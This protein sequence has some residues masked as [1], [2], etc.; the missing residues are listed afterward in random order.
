VSNLLKLI[1]DEDVLR[2][3][4][5]Y[6]GAHTGRVSASTSK[7]SGEEQTDRR[8]NPLNIPKF[9]VFGVD[10]RGMLIPRPGHKFM[11]YDYSQIEARIVQWMAGNAEFLEYVRR[12]GDIYQA[13]AKFVGWYSGTNLKKDNPGMRQLSK[14]A[15]L[16]LGYGMGPDKFIVTADKPMYGNLKISEGQAVQVVGEFRERNN[17][18]VDLWHYHHDAMRLS[19]IMQDPTHVI[20][21]PSGRKMTYY[22]PHELP[23]FRLFKNRET[24]KMENK[25]VTELFAATTMY[26]PPEKYFGGKIV[27]NVVQSTARDIMFHGACSIERAHPNWYFLFNAYDEVIFEVPETDVPLAQAEMPRLLCDVPWAA[28]CPLEVD[29]GKTNGVHDRYTK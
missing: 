17:K 9:P 4:L 12:E 10:L 11:I 25:A 23:G 21:I 6:F 28:G 8:F 19:A 27:E 13:Y 24:G 1:D 26:E 15:V 7:K 22:K 5:I 2:F 3:S 29:G 14:V 16:G 20:T 18:V